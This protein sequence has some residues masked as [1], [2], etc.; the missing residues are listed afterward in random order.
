MAITIVITDD[1]PDVEDIL[2]LILVFE[3]ELPKNIF[4]NI[5]DNIVI[6]NII[7]TVEF[8]IILFTKLY[9]SFNNEFISGVI[10]PI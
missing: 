2:P 4:K 10:F 7:I 9:V 5:Y 8:V 1:V 6:A 3:P